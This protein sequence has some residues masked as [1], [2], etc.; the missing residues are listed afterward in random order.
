MLI[1][2]EAV[3]EY[4]KL[5]DLT[6]SQKAHLI[7]LLDLNKEY[8]S[9]EISSLVSEQIISLAQR[10]YAEDWKSA[11][12][13]ALIT[14][15]GNARGYLE[16][17][18]DYIKDFLV[19]PLEPAHDEAS[20]KSAIGVKK[21]R[22]RLKMIDKLKEP[23]LIKV[24]GTLFPAA[25]LNAGWWE[26]VREKLNIEW[27][28]SLQQWLFEGFD[29]WAPSWD[30]SWDFEG[31]DK[32]T[33]P[34]Y[35]AQLTD[36][37]EAD[38]LAVIIPP[39]LAKEW[40]EKFRMSWGGFEV[41]ITGVL[42]HRY[43]ARNELP[44][45]GEFQGQAQDYCIWLKD[46]DEQ[47]HIVERTEATDLYSGYLWQC[48]IPRQWLEEN[49]LIGLNQVYMV[50]EH[51]NFAARDALKYNLSS[52][53]HKAS[54]IEKMHRKQG[55]L[56]LL[57]KSHGVLVPGDPLWPVEDFYKLLLH[58]KVRKPADR[59]SKNRQQPIP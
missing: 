22:E 24:R 38:S 4:D 56:V 19:D 23:Q 30:I 58:E 26:S 50:W 6:T 11:I 45:E 33:K 17:K 34:Y 15:L 8:I 18:L 31:R 10:Q 21:L 36:G 27:K 39:K 57:Q 5:K 28:N 48:L 20:N 46:D 55:G 44:A 53:E 12:D 41:E 35:V 37:D 9:P 59:M 49:E 40:R 42:G 25:L 54:Q 14:V 2:N 32:N 13:K 47:Y 16:K 1:K 3:L 52:L 7:M 29:L 43:Q 51:T